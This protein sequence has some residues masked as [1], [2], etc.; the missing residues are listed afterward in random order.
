MQKRSLTIAAASL[1]DCLVG[2]VLLVVWAVEVE[3]GDSLMTFNNVDW[4][5]HLIGLAWQVPFHSTSR[6]NCT[7]SNIIY[8]RYVNY[9]GRRA[10]T[11]YNDLHRRTHH[12]PQHHSL[13]SSHNELWEKEEETPSLKLAFLSYG[14]QRSVVLQR[15]RDKK[16]YSRLS[17]LVI[18]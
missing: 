6:T 9:N 16:R 15:Q 8:K 4:H 14:K 11:Q 12:L 13:L 2:V 18:C 7:F 3:G 1:F 10:G 5:N 17:P